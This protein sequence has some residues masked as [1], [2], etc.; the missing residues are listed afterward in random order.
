MSGSNSDESCILEV[1]SYFLCVLTCHPTCL[2]LSLAANLEDSN[3]GK[4]L[5]A[6]CHGG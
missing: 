4:G 1:C 3:G 2:H 6:S 5:E